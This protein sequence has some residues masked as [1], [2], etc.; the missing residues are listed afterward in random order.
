MIRGLQLAEDYAELLPQ[1][2]KLVDD[3]DVRVIFQATLSIGNFQGA[4]V[5]DAMAHIQAKYES[6]PWFN[7]AIQSASE[8]ST[9]GHISE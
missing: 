9:L 6:D 1:M 7:I 2:L 5:V 8:S 3:E 4:S